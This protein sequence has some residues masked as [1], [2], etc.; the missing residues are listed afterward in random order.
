MANDATRL[1]TADLRRRLLGGAAPA[2]PAGAPAQPLDAQAIA[3]AYPDLSVD[4][5]SITMPLA[6]NSEDEPAIEAPPRPTP[7]PVARLTPPELRRPELRPAL[8]PR[9]LT[10]PAAPLTERPA[11]RSFVAAPPAPVAAP[12]EAVAPERPAPPP[13][14][15]LPRP[16]VPPISA[17]PDSMASHFGDMLVPQPDPEMDHLRKENAQL[18]QLMEEMRQLLQEASEQEQRMQAEVNDREQKLTAAQA[19][20]EEFETIINTKPK[21]KSE[22]EEWADEL[23][24]ESFQIAQ[25]RRVLEEDRKQLREDETTLEK[26]MRDMEVQMARE[27]ALLARQEQELKRLNAEIQHELELMQRGDAV[28]RERLAVFQRRHAEV[29]SADGP[30]VATSYFGNV[31]S[32][33]A[34]AP[35]VAT[36][37]PP[38]AGPGRKN[39]SSTGL[40]RKLFRSE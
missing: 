37:L 40:L 16:V 31:P 5:E 38:A 1:S 39:D 7:V 23:E 30:P 25:E 20:I 4:D 8:N 15:V 35:P 9:P 36:P 28:L 21:T 32:P 34:A 29:V 12:P 17:R 2:N 18:Q 26:Q 10:P 14:N 33:V 22:L 27:R 11:S 24:R 6:D 3:N 13:A 19:R